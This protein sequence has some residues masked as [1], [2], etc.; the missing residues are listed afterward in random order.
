MA[1]GSKATVIGLIA[2]IIGALLVMGALSFVAVSLLMT[3]LPPL[4]FVA[5]VV[6]I[7]L[8]LLGAAAGFFMMRGH[9]L[10]GRALIV[11][12]ICLVINTAFYVVMFVRAASDAAIRP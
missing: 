11:L 2:I 10:A 6:Q 4:I 3:G 5:P 1:Q 9:A 12:A 7:L 8:G